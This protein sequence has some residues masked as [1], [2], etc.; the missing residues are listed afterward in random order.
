M[1]ITISKPD[2]S[3]L[4]LVTPGGVVLVRDGEELFDTGVRM[5]TPIG[6]D[7]A[8]AMKVAWV[9]GMKCAWRL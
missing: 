4:L 5:P 9:L 3:E 8:Y 1:T 6:M 2:A 7:T